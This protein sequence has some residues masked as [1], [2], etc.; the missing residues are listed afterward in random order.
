MFF[1]LLIVFWEGCE[2]CEKE[3]RREKG[4]KILN[5]ENKMGYKETVITKSVCYENDNPVF[6]E[7]VT[8]ITVNDE[9]GGGFIVLT[10]ND[11][12]STG[13]LK[14]DKGELLYIAEIAEKMLKE[15]EKNSKTDL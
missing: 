2:V 6:G 3:F 7:S 9:A 11:E 5:K 12:D 13:K 10:Q 4:L 15:Y 8:N 1:T 14:F